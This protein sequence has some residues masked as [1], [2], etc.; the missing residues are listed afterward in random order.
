[1]NNELLGGLDDTQEEDNVVSMEEH[2]VKRKAFHEW[3]VNGVCHKLKLKTSMVE[4][5]ENKYREN[6]LNLISRDGVPPLSVM[7]T[8]IQAAIQPWE[9]NVAYKDVVNLYDAWVDNEDGNQME[10]LNK[11]IIP[12]MAVSGF[13]TPEQA[14]SIMSSLNEAMDM[15]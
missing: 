3:E 6:L 15:L 4:K 1:M 8:I 14:E 10:L 9:H 11:V 13:F 5:L 12:T 7:L 2:K